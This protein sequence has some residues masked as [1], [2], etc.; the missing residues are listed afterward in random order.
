MQMKS[1]YVGIVGESNYQSAVR[2]LHEGFRVDL[3]PEPDNRH[4]PNAIRVDSITGETIGYVPRD[5]WLTDA[6]IGQGVDCFAVVHELTGEGKRN[7]GV[8]I[9]VWLGDDAAEARESH[10]RKRKG[11]LA[12]LAL[13][14]LAGVIGLASVPEV[15]AQSGGWDLSPTRVEVSARAECA[16]LLPGNFSLQV[17]CID[18]YHEGARDFAEVAGR[19]AG[20]RDM[21][22]ALAGCY[23]LL[24]K[25]G[26][27]NYGLLGICAKDQEQSYLKL[28]GR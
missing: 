25:N 11:C 8:V 22:A 28:N 14:L 17:I 16:A 13:P 27:T 19:A 3:V 9:E 12:L 5:S 15:R 24:T 1:Y 2:M 18:G 21:Q 23:E 7:R 20:N 26:T 4:D 10:V 6:I